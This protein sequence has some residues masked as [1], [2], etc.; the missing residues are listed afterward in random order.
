MK[1]PF[2]Q[3]SRV[4][5]CKLDIE[6]ISEAY[7]RG[8]NNQ[9]L[10]F[11][12]THAL[13]PKNKK[14]LENYLVEKQNNRD[15]WLG[16]YSASAQTHIGNIELFQFN[17]QTRSAKFAILLWDELGKG[18]AREASTLLIDHAFKSIGL[19]RIELGVHAENERAIKLYQS[20][21]F[22]QEGILRQ[23]G[24]KGGKYFDVIHMSILS[25]DYLK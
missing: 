17:N 12:T 4:H 7:L 1:I 2:L 8:V 23:A 19:N 6:D 18:F 3:N 20:L 16:I 5:L 21:G 22:I 24:Y 13:Y 9:D 15:I 10:D 11:Y 25:R 14:E